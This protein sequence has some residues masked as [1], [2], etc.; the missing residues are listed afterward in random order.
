VSIPHLANPHYVGQAY[1]YI[2]E[3]QSLGAQVT[4]LEAGGYEHL[5]KQV[6]QVEDLIASKVDAI[7]IAA[8]S[9]PGTIGAVEAAAAAGI[10]VINV[11]VMT[12]SDKVV[13]RIR[14]DDDVIGRMQADFM[15]ERLKGTG[16]VVML[17]GAPGT[18]WAEI[19]GNAFRKQ[20][21]AK[22]PNVK[23]LGEQ[24][25]QSTPADARRSPGV[26][27]DCRR[28]DW[29]RQNQW[30]SGGDRH[31]ADGRARSRHSRERA[32]PGAGL[33]VHPKHCHRRDHRRRCVRRP[34][35]RAAPVTPRRDGQDGRDG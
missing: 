3:A 15:G 23:V 4:L 25:S 32:E 8:V 12:D 6:S 2:D 34:G 29:R 18:S 17:R 7:I 11:N 26:V 1:G 21:A 5:D 16:N 35:A 19:R 20:L 28:G 9:G 30:W 14:S 22:Y 13:T 33:V 24:Y 31:D 10:P 27:F